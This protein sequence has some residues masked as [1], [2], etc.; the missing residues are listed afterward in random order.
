MTIWTRY[1]LIWLG[2][3]LLASHVSLGYG[4]TE[5]GLSDCVSGFLLIAFGALSLSN[6]RIWSPWAACFVGVWLQAAP[7]LFWAS[8]PAAYLNDTLVG[9]LAIAL[10]ILIPGIP[11]SLPE[12]GPSVPP[13]WSYNPS[14]WP[15]RLPVVILG[16]VGWF[17]SRYL[18]AVQLG[19]I[20]HAWDPVFDMGT[21]NVITSDVS[22]AFPV[23]DAGLGAMAYTLEVL[24]ALKGGERRWRTMPWMVLL[25]GLVVVPL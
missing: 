9:I 3:W 2:F 10:S 4:W 12:T 5:L 16:T 14:S 23:S 25:F 24:L 18:A 7:L 1:T 19:Y 6:R 22:K 8:S 13:G 11:G 17:I 15:Q 20:P 21:M